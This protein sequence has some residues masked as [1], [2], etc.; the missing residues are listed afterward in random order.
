M[1]GSTYPVALVLE[2]KRC[3]VA[4]GGS[5]AAEKVEGLLRA[6]AVVT[7]VSPEVSAAIERPAALGE[8]TLHRRPYEPADLEGTYLA[9]G[10][11]EDRELNARVAADARR[12]GVIVNAVDD[13]PNCDFFAVSLVRRGALQIAISTDGR[14]PAFAR[15]MREEL[16]AR[17]PQELG[18]L[19][20]VLAEVRLE[21]RAGGAV[22]AY[23]RW[24][25]AIGGALERLRAGDREGARAY[26]YET[27]TESAAAERAVLPL[28]S[29]V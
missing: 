29:E 6:G 1:K 23:E 22:P 8:I 7:V 15:W 25:A 20:D 3:L 28:G 12:A 2:G 27:L 16:D 18:A 4:G 14:S 24:K 13:I 11:T 9:Y 10:A 21:I 26:V 17:L 19:L 5:L